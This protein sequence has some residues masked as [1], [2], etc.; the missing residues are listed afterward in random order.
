LVWILGGVRVAGVGE[1]LSVRHGFEMG[2]AHLVF[3]VILHG[4]YRL[5]S[6]LV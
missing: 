1:H 6:S 3:V 5:R 4:Q 2:I